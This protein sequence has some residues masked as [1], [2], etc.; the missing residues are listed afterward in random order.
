[1]HSCEVIKCKKLGGFCKTA[2]LW[3]LAKFA[4]TKKHYGPN[5]PG[6]TGTG[7]VLGA[8]SPMG[9]VGGAPARALGLTQGAAGWI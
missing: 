4:A 7:E 1:M 3:K 8:F 6:P 2:I 5:L 9:L